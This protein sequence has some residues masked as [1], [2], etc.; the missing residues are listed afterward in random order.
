M[1]FAAA[2]ATV[3]PR[4]AETGST[5][6]A[7]NHV[8]IN[9]PK[10]LQGNDVMLAAIAVR[11]PLPPAGWTLVRRDNDNANTL[12]QAVYFHGGKRTGV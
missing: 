9:Q 5:T 8:T 4:S 3:T 2:S 11:Q 7:D 1:A 12:A 10:G 6:K